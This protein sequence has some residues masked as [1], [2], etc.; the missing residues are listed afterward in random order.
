[1]EARASALIQA[2]E[3]E[4]AV[5]TV[6]TVEN[7]TI[8]S[9]LQTQP[10]PPLFLDL[11][12]VRIPEVMDESVVT[13]ALAFHHHSP[14]AAFLTEALYHHQHQVLVLTAAGADLHCHTPMETEL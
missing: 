11:Q 6:I 2:T 8:T 14:S 12:T 1:M 9:T 3:V 4:A 10:I 7:S 13:L 5:S